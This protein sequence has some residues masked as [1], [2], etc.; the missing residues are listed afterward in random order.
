MRLLVLGHDVQDVI[1]AIRR[2]EVKSALE[3]G[4][5]IHELI[6]KEV[7]A[8]ADSK[9]DFE[10]LKSLVSS[11]ELEIFEPAEDTVYEPHRPY[12]K[13][14]RRSMSGSRPKKGKRK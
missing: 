11:L 13:A 10:E 9:A 3:R 1:D 12:G 14:Y 8:E 6:S 5:L 4:R 7:I 2:L